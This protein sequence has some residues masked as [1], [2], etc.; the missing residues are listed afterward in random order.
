VESDS[1]YLFY[2]LVELKLVEWIDRIL[3]SLIRG[4]DQPQLSRLVNQCLSSRNLQILFLKASIV[5]K[6]RL[7]QVV[8]MLKGNGTELTED[9]KKLE[10]LINRYFVK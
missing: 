4:S 9:G 8:Q 5:Y 2:K 3:D 6:E 1:R 7:R 10:E